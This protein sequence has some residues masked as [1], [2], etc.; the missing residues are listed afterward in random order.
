[1]INFNIEFPKLLYFDFVFHSSGRLLNLTNVTSNDSGLYTCR[2][3]TDTILTDLRGYL[4]AEAL[5]E[6][7]GVLE[8]WPGKCISSLFK[9]SIFIVLKS[10]CMFKS[11]YVTCI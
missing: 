2:I 9:W 4:T 6:V 11:S 10:A 7:I 1:M 5:V 8:Y 3:V